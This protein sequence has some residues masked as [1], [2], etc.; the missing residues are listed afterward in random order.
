M[1]MAMK[2]RKA[3]LLRKEL[4]KRKRDRAN[5]AARKSWRSTIKLTHQSFVDLLHNPVVLGLWIAIYGGTSLMVGVLFFD[6][7]DQTE[8][9][10]LLIGTSPITIFVQSF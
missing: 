9:Y 5:F 7:V 6:L 2:Q 1:D 4:R 3:I 8:I 10:A